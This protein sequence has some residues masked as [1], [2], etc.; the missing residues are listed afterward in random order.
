MTEEEFVDRF[1]GQRI[2]L[3]YDDGDGFHGFYHVC[4]IREPIGYDSN[5]ESD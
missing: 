4:D 2:Q 1:D 3:Y 5:D